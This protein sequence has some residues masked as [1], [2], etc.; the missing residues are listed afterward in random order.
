M[1]LITDP[2]TV[3]KSCTAVFEAEN[4]EEGDEDSVGRLVGGDR[5]DSG[6]A[7]PDG[8]EDAAVDDPLVGDQAVRNGQDG[9]GPVLTQPRT[10]VGV[11]GELDPRPPPQPRV[12]TR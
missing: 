1:V 3:A 2:N 11:D 8:V 12:V 6:A 9:V 10:P 5:I 7:G 4:A